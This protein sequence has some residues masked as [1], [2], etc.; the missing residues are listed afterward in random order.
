MGV[1]PR[2][3]VVDPNHECHDLPGLYVTDGSSVPS[4]IAVNPQ[5]TIMTLATR[6][7]E[8]IGRRLD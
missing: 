8:R 3:S 4:S 6:A 7:A 2:R 5:V 1:D